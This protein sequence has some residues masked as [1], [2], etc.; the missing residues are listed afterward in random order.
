MSQYSRAY[1]AWLSGKPVDPRN[2][3]ASLMHLLPDYWCYEYRRA[4]ARP[5]N[6]LQVSESGFEYL[7]DLATE[8]GNRFLRGADEDRLVAAFGLSKAIAAPH[9][10][11][12]RKSFLGPSGKVLGKGYEKGHALARQFGGGLDINLIPMRGDVNRGRDFREMEKYA[13][14]HPGT[15]VFNR[16]LYRDATWRPAE[17]EYGVL[18]VEGNL[19]VERFTNY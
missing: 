14:N 4:A 7:F 17:I 10:D 18:T 16:P 6:I 3:S 5:I 12:R 2:R 1:Q 13:A 8:I 11:N 9:D 15:F 19:W